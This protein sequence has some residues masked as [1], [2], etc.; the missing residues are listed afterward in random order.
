MDRPH[1]DPLVIELVIAE[2]EIT[3]ILIE[4]GSSLDLIFRET[5]KRMEIKDSKIQTVPK[6]LTGFAGEIT[7]SIRT[8]KL[9]VFVQGITK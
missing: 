9:H 2:Y 1:E 5:L 4:T 8:I 3:C 7:M 6:P